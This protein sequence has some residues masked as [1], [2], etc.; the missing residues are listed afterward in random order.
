MR[1]RQGTDDA[2]CDLPLLSTTIVHQWTAVL[3]IQGS[4]YVKS[5]RETSRS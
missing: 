3:R 4:A 5:L 1:A 2:S